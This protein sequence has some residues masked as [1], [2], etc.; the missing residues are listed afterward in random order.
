MK[1]S[2]SYILFLSA[3]YFTKEAAVRLVKVR[4]ETRTVTIVWVNI[5]SVALLWSGSWRYPAGD[6]AEE[7]TLKD[8]KK[9]QSG[10]KWRVHLQEQRRDMRIL[11]ENAFSNARLSLTHT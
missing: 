2:P 9:V 4:A 8:K 5:H 10:N 11:L 1:V 7:W 6:P 3:P